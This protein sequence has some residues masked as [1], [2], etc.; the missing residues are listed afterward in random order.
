MISKLREPSV[1]TNS[2]LTAM[3][4]PRPHPIRLR[5]ASP[6]QPAPHTPPDGS[7]PTSRARPGRY[8]SYLPRA[9]LKSQQFVSGPPRAPAS[10]ALC[11]SWTAQAPNSTSPETAQRMPTWSN[12]R[13]TLMTDARTP[14]LQKVV[15]V[16]CAGPHT[17]SIRR[18]SP[19]PPAHG[20]PALTRR[21]GDSLRRA[22]QLK[23]LPPTRARSAG[24]HPPIHIQIHPRPPAAVFHLSGR[25]PA[26]P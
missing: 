25:R 23:P 9:C 14:R 10:S 13:A 11:C 20:P 2:F 26:A 4:P 15:A 7:A 21:V 6:R 18:P 17:P 8:L 24:T 5:P 1:N 22:M 12:A 19:P 3:I 16:A